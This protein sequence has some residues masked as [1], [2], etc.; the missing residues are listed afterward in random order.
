MNNYNYRANS[1]ALYI[2]WISARD[3]KACF[4]VPSGSN[5]LQN[6]SKLRLMGV[7]LCCFT[8]ASP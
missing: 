5:G 4:A 1:Q 7:F 2:S 3:Q 8:R 6:E